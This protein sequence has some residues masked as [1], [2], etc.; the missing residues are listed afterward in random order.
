MFQWSVLLLSPHSAKHV[1]FDVY[2]F[3]TTLHG[4]AVV[5]VLEKIAGILGI[6]VSSY[7]SITCASF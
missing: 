3:S 2:L 7:F 1:V 5:V 6:C 4:G